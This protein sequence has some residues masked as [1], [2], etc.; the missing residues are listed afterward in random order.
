VRFTPTVRTEGP[1]PDTLL[2][3]AASAAAIAD[4]LA[5]IAD[6]E[7]DSKRRRLA[8]TSWLSKLRVST[9]HQ[10]P[11]RELRLRCKMPATRLAVALGVSVRTLWNAEY[12]EGHTPSDT[13]LYAA[14]A[15]ASGQG[16]GD[17]SRPLR[18]ILRERKARAEER[19]AEG[20]G[21]KGQA[22]S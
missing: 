5:A 22:Q 1:T 18:A 19:R 10:E 21:P 11:M 8:A 14:A 17:I 15:Y 7:M 2:I 3:A 6:T 4:Q 9:R 16:W 13:L 20:V 12:R